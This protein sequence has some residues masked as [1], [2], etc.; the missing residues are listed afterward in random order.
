MNV[1]GALVLSGLVVA[2][3]STS[4][5]SRADNIPTPKAS[6]SGGTLVVTGTG[7]Y[8]VNGGGPWKW[9][10]ATGAPTFQN[11]D[12]DNHCDSATFKGKSC[13]GTVKAFVC[14]ATNCAPPISVPVTGS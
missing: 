7:G 10:Q 1:I 6:C 11:C 14:T 3:V 4:A 2:V 5:P 13:T 9:D 8:R 12:R